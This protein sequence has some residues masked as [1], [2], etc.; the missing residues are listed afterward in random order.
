MTMKLSVKDIIGKAVIAEEEAYEF[1]TEAAKRIKSP[2]A[3]NMFET[4]AKEELRHKESLKKLDITVLDTK[5]LKPNQ[6]IK[7]CEKVLLTPVSELKEIQDVF[8]LAIKREQ[9]AHDTY[10]ELAKVFKPST[11]KELFL[12]LAKMEKGH[13]RVLEKEYDSCF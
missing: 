1:Y 13:K 9:E 10:A 11:E 7:V 8:I 4:L 6:Q 3:V 5:T 2:S 12:E